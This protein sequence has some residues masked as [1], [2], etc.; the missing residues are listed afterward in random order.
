MVLYPFIFLLFFR[1]VATITFP[2]S[3]SSSSSTSL[4]CL[5]P[6]VPEN[7]HVIF[8]EPGPYARDTV[9]K[10]SCALGF[11]LIGSEERTCLSDGSWSDEPPICAIDVA[12][13]K[14]VTQSS[15]NVATALGG[16]L[17][18]MT[19]DESKSFW[20]V[21]LLGDYSIRSISMKL[22]TKSSPIVSVEAIETGGAVHQ[23]IVDSSL[24]TANQTTSISCSYDTVS[25]LRITATRRLHLCQVNVYAV[26]A[27]SGK[28]LIH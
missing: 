19:N 18:T 9:A 5:Q 13:N 1:R 25:R 24:F 17:C 8:N 20:E 21:D 14:P 26:N 22:G 7:A 2:P 15:G 3:S 16:T 23:C 4:F 6:F 10:Y 12:F 11:D 27:E 28:V